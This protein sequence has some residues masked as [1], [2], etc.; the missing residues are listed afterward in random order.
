MERAA[1]PLRHHGLQR[2]ARAERGPAETRTGWSGF[3]LAPA[4]G[5][6]V[7]RVTTCP[8]SPAPCRRRE[9]VRDASDPRSALTGNTVLIN[10]GRDE[11]SA[12]SHLQK[13]SVRVEAGQRVRGDD[14]NRKSRQ[15]WQF[16]TA[17]PALPAH[18]RARLV[19][20]QQYTSPVYQCLDRR[21]HDAG[22]AGREGE[23]G[24]PAH[25]QVAR[26]RPMTATVS[27][28]AS[29]PINFSRSAPYFG[30]LLLVALI[31][32]WPTYLSRPFTADTHTHLHA[33]TATLW[34]LML[35]AQ[36]SGHTDETS[37]AASTAWT[38]FLRVGAP[39]PHEH[40]IAR[41]QQD[42][43]P[44]RRPERWDLQLSLTALFASFLCARILT[45]R[46]VALHARF[47]VC[48]ALTL[49]DPVLVRMM[50]LGESEPDMDISMVTFAVTD[51]MF[52]VFIWRAACQQALCLPRCSYLF[53]RR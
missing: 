11:S 13:D 1:L 43:W 9:T 40:G 42:A 2:L 6:V 53:S 22:D 18:G 26:L 35:V 45:R 28:V 48:T 23:A 14:E 8:T 29:R 36:P 12:L 49:I 50:L 19:P 21:F 24:N 51:L 39:R 37:D 27:R 47:M 44:E 34:M 15:F 7:L 46:T 33:L 30:G 4:S 5:V 52:V 38:H 25:G 16:G 20:Q 10:H 32:F 41:P 3:R 17:A 31:A